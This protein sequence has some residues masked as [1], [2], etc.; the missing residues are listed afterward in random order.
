MVVCLSAQS[1]PVHNITCFGRSGMFFWPRGL[2]DWTCLAAD[3]ARQ[4]FLRSVRPP[5]RLLCLWLSRAAVIRIM[6]MARPLVSHSADQDKAR[7][8]GKPLITSPDFD[9]FLPTYRAAVQTTP[10]HP[11]LS[12]LHSGGTMSWRFVGIHSPDG[13]S[14]VRIESWTTDVA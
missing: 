2:T 4:S 3:E 9:F 11:D 14:C 7:Q 6:G 12:T 5:A 8:R 1:E 13:A 10:H